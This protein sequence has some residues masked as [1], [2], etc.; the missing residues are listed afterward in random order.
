MSIDAGTEHLAPEQSQ[1][2]TPVESQAPF[3]RSKF[4]RQAGASCSVSLCSGPFPRARPLP[5]TIR[6]L[7]LVGTAPPATVV[8]A[9]TA[10][11]RTVSTATPAVG[12][13]GMAGAVATSTGI[14]G[15]TCAAGTTGTTGQRHGVH[16]L[17]MD[18][19]LLTQLDAA[20]TTSAVEQRRLVA[21][22]CGIWG[23][24][25]SV[26]AGSRNGRG[27]SPRC[28]PRA[29]PT[30]AP[31]RHQ[32]NSRDRDARRAAGDRDTRVRCPA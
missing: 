30:D 26:P 28:S 31:L 7:G 5:R 16:L 19:V 2:N 4:L 15:T 3:E 25:R 29:R 23:L 9:A 21:H 13:L 20:S 32:H 17:A 8:A 12:R 22:R 24:N 18:F 14:G 1:P 11:R 6:P 10:A 27:V